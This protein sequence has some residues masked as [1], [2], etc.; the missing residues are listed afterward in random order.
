MKKALTAIIFLSFLVRFN[1]LIAQT[2]IIKYA[3]PQTYLAG[4]PITPAEPD[5]Y[6]RC[7]T[8]HKTPFI[9]I[10]NTD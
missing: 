10:I 4:T 1:N 6:G 7:C 5:K 3:S 2:P 9:S 8:C